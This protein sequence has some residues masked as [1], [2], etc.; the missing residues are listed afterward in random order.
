MRIKI[1]NISQVL[2]AL[3]ILFSVKTAEAADISALDFNGDL[4]GKV[5]PDGSVI[6]FDNELIGHITADGFVLNDDKDLIGGVVP[7]GI[8]ISV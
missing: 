2:L 5:I 4:L 8:A 1:S 7:Q 6:N 3:G